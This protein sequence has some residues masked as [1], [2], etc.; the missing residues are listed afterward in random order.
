TLSPFAEM[1]RS[2]ETARRERIKRI[3]D[4][5]RDAFERALSA[6]GRI[7]SGSGI[8]A[9]A[10]ARGARGGRRLLVGVGGA[11]AAA[12]RAATGEAGALLGIDG[13]GGI[14]KGKIADLCGFRLHGDRESPDLRAALTGGRPAL[15]VQGG[16]VVRNRL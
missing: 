12:L 14:A 3:F 11:A 2:A 4:A 15:V 7:A 9:G 1:G 16:K 13:L 10:H 8:G 6:G 5:M